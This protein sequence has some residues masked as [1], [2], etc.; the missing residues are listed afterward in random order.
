MILNSFNNKRLL[1]EPG[2]LGR[3]NSVENYE[4]I[5]RIGEGTYGV[6]YKAKDKATGQIVALKKIRMEPEPSSPAKGDAKEQKAEHIPPDG[7]PL[8]H[9]REIQLLMSLN[10]PNV[11]SVL[12]IV[13]GSHL[14]SIFTVMEYC[15]HDM[16]AL[17]DS[18]T[19]P[20]GPAEIKCLMHQL[21]R[22]LEFLHDH[23]VIH[24]D[25]K[26]SNLL[27]SSDGTLKIADFGL[28]RKFGNPPQSM[29]PK[30]VTLW[31]RSPELLYGEVN[32]TTAIDVWSVGCIFGEFLCNS[33][34]FP[35]STELQQF[36]LIVDLMGE[37][38]LEVWPEMRNLPL[39][40]EFQLR[41]QPECKTDVKFASQTP[42][43][44]NLL[45]SML[46]Y[47]PA[48]RITVAQALKHTY[49]T[50]PPKKADKRLLRT[51]PDLRNDL[52]VADGSRAIPKPKAAPESSAPTKRSISEVT[53]SSENATKLSKYIRK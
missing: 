53:G 7:L 3:C 14:G 30:V 12:D 39:Y 16:A 47:R 21:L 9:F 36:N 23:Y 34:L 43:C 8:A 17:L 48:S 51:L 49:F 42:N 44:L 37:P 6:V 15:V 41:I 27:L 2:F 40:S 13:V 5:S 35:G 11:V 1:V 4:K 26:L 29:T 31:Y 25:L 38:T 50:E 33:P 32:Y 22:G 46:A 24:R 20:F 10:H 28:A 52:N 19:Q 18:M 45:E